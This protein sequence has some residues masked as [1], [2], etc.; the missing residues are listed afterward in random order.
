MNPGSER[1]PRARRLEVY[2]LQ[3]RCNQPELILNYRKTGKISAGRENDIYNSRA[4]SQK[5]SCIFTTARR[6]ARD[7]VIGIKNNNTLGVLRALCRRHHFV[8]GYKQDYLLEMALICSPL[9]ASL[10]NCL[11]FF[12]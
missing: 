4:G 11:S 3:R 5:E 7:E 12:V 2:F 1:Y 8:T 6:Q 10:G 9:P